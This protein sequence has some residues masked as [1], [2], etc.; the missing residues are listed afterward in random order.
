M[1]THPSYGWKPKKGLQL[2]PIEQ[3]FTSPI[4]ARHMA[5]IAKANEELRR[6]RES[7]KGKMIERKEVKLIWR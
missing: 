1:S 4:V 7:R 3:Q 5:E 2:I 6:W